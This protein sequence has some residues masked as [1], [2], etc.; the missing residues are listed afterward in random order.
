MQCELYPI[1]V[2]INVMGM[3]LVVCGGVRE[4]VTRHGFLTFLA[5]F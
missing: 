5:K 4:V 1:I 2:I 3:T